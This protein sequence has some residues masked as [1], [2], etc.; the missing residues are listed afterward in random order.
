MNNFL[1]INYRPHLLFKLKQI[2]NELYPMIY[3][4]S[5]EKRIIVQLIQKFFVLV[6]KLDK[7]YYFEK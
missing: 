7:H 3:S 2:F 4:I 6:E 1:N 5:D